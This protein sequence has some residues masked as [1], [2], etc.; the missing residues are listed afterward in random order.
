MRNE[1]QRVSNIIA[2]LKRLPLPKEIGEVLHVPIM[3]ET[4]E[5]E[6]EMYDRG[7]PSLNEET[8]QVLRLQADVVYHH[9]SPR[10]EWFIT[11]YQ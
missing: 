11:I 2:T 3:K 9:G 8:V 5:Y 7:G 10:L 1:K 4:W 6:F